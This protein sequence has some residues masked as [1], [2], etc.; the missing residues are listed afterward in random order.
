MDPYASGSK[1]LEHVREHVARIERFRR[2][3]EAP[4]RLATLAVRVQDHDALGERH[5]QRIVLEDEDAVLDPQRAGTARPLDTDGH[6]RPRLS[7]RFRTDRTELGDEV[8]SGPAAY[9]LR[10]CLTTRIT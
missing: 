5:D 9:R 3:V 7:H 1:P 4:R 6:A 2:H 10:R 8:Q